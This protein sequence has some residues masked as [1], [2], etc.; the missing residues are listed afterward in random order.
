MKRVRIIRDDYPEDPRDWGNV[1]TMICW[2]SKY[3]LGDPHKY[4]GIVDVALGADPD[5]DYR[6]DSNDSC[7]TTF[8]HC[9]LCDLGY[10][11]DDAHEYAID[12]VSRNASTMIKKVLDQ[13]YLMLP[14][15]LYDHSGITMRTTPFNC[16][17]DSGQV[18][19]IVCDKEIINW[20][21]N[22]EMEK[23]KQAL[24]DEVATYDMYLGGE[25][26]GYI[27]EELVEGE[28]I[29]IDSCCGFFGSDPKT[30]GMVE[31]FGEDLLDKVE[32]EDTL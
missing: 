28:W 19:W 32:Y 20:E 25:V 3:N 2:H 6:L 21:F 30:N 23:T 22:G 16:R 7:Y 12:K 27:V 13:H 31:Y 5:L 24:I 8:Y 14:L 15:Y 11:K 9:A 4:S 17:W 10:G 18:G 29:I 26:Y 1:G